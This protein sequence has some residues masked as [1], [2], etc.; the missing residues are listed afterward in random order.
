MRP[1]CLPS[2]VHLIEKRIILGWHSHVIIHTKPESYHL[3][4]SDAR[5][6]Q[7]MSTLTYPFSS[8]FICLGFLIILHLPPNGAHG[9]KATLFFTNFVQQRRQILPPEHV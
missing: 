7:R 2:G 9:A 5:A 4:S 8:P 6:P 1:I 3:R